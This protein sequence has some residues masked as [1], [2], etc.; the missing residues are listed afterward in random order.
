V[1]WIVEERGGRMLYRHFRRTELG[2]QATFVEIF[3]PTPRSLTHAVNALE[4]QVLSTQVF[5]E[6]QDLIRRYYIVV[7]LLM[8]FFILFVSIWLAFYL[9]RG[10]VEPIEQLAVATQRV[11]EGEVGYQV[12]LEE[13]LDRDFALL[14]NSFNAMSRDLQE[15]RQGLIRT[16][17]HLQESNRVLEEH[18]RFVD[19][20]LENISTGVVSLDMDGRIE[21]INRTAKQILQLKTAAFQGKHFG[22]VLERESLAGFEEMFQS[23]QANP[24]KSVMRN[25]TVSKQGAPVHVSSGLF[26]LENREGKP[27]GM[28]SVYHNITEMQRL[29]RAQAWREVARR[30]AHEVKNPLTPIQLSAERIRRK[31]SGLIENDTTLEQ[32]TRTIIQEVQQLKQM[33]SEFSNFA[34]IPESNPQA[35]D[36]NSIILEAVQLYDGNL[37]ARIRLDTHLA[38]DLPSLPLD[39]EQIRRVFINLIDNAIDAIENKGRLSRIFKQGVIALTTRLDPELRIVRVEVEDNGTG[40][41]PEIADRLF[42]PYATTKDDG[43]GLGLTILHQTL[44]DHNGFVR[45]QNLESG[46]ACFTLELPVS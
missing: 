34:K 24:G 4:K 28:V 40:I 25:L 43:T 1:T 26:A 30:I 3:R 39:R 44:A 10:F 11:S 19:L 18:T 29:Q 41:E 8:T 46:G 32:A 35:N 27:V 31:Y 16:T 5:V 33:V 23:L 17:E 21:G 38:P 20:V 13:P 6:S 22:E 45:F 7:F 14:V 9:A 12:T 37:P 42:E 15:Y 2:G 36:L